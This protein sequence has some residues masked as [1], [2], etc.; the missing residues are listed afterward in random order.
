MLRYHPESC[1]LTPVFIMERVP[2][3]RLRWCYGCYHVFLPG[4]PRI[5]LQPMLG[6]TSCLCPTSSFKLQVTY[7]SVESKENL[8]TSALSGN[9]Y[10][11]YSLSSES[12]CEVTTVRLRRSRRC[13]QT[14]PALGLICQRRFRII[15]S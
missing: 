2:G 8:L 9:G 10:I 14:S 7:V 5:A 4:I 12:R 13:S 11:S 15:I 6:T 1:S 3:Q